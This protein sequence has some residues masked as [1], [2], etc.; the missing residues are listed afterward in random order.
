MFLCLYQLFLLNIGYI[1]SFF[2][3]NFSCSSK[4]GKQRFP[5]S[6]FDSIS[7]KNIWKICMNKCNHL[8]LLYFKGRIKVNMELD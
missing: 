3:D 6:G 2:T 8:F 7:D 5:T 4:G 1:D